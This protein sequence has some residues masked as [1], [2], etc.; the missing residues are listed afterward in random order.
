MLK[1][2]GERPPIRDSQKR[3]FLMRHSGL[4]SGM[5]PKASRAHR[6][7]YRTRTSEGSCPR[8]VGISQAQSSD[9]P[10]TTR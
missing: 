6:G 1:L 3:P 7:Q 5:G 4:I 10:I 8:Y 9:R 2:P